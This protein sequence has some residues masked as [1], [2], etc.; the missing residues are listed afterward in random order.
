M[1]PSNCVTHHHACEC[2]EYA[3]MGLVDDMLFALHLLSKFNGKAKL[4][5]SDIKNFTARRRDL[6]GKRKEQPK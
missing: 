2:R 4:S 1:K 6:W 5:K 3:A